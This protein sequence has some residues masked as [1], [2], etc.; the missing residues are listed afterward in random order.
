MLKLRIVNIC[1]CGGCWLFCAVVFFVKIC[2]GNNLIYIYF[3]ITVLGMAVGI[4]DFSFEAG[5]YRLGRC[6]LFLLW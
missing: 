2:V 3:L 6:R 5:I 4:L 1:H